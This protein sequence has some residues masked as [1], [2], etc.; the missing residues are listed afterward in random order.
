[1][2]CITDRMRAVDGATQ[3]HIVDLAGSERQRRTVNDSARL[4]EA[5][6]INESIMTLMNCLRAMRHNQVRRRSGWRW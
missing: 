1:M 4:V 2:R 5:G 3:V 6:S